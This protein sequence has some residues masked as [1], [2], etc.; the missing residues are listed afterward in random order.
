MENWYIYFATELLGSMLLIILGNGVVANVSLKG[1]KEYK[2]SNFLTIALGWGFAVAVG[3]L[4]STAIG[5]SSGLELKGLGQLNPAITFGLIVNN[6]ESN[7]GSWGL[8]PIILVGQMLGFIIGQILVDLVYFNQIKAYFRRT[9]EDFEK[10]AKS[11]VLGMHG[12]VPQNRVVWTNFLMEFLG[13]TV[14][15]SV[16]FVLGLEGVGSGIGVFGPIFVMI[17]LMG[18]GTALSG[19]TGYAVNP[20]R[21][22][23]PRIVYQVMIFLPFANRLES[24][25]WKYSW[26]PVA[27]PLAAGL[28]VGAFFLI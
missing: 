27:A 20:F 19:T 4:V 15:V 14:L 26:I 16:V 28:V 17:A 6:W 7:V 22:L 1:T 21:D 3:A 25:D 24:P 11:T 18:I 5:Q 13:T 9:N 23:M 12:T 8:L 2:N 10:N